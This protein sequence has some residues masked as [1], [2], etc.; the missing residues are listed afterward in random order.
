MSFAR[1]SQVVSLANPVLK[2]EFNH[3]R[4]VIQQSRSGWF[5]IL[6]AVLMIVP[7]LISSVIYFGLAALDILPII[8]FYSFLNTPHAL[9]GLLLVLV[10][11]SLYPVVSLITMGLAANSIRREKVN[12]TWGILILTEVRPA[13]VVF[14]K[15]WASLRA[16]NGDQIMVV[17][18]RIGLIGLYTSVIL[19]AYLALD[20]IFIPQRFYFLLLVPIVVIHA[21]LD[22][23]LTSA[24]GVLA[25]IPE[26]N[27]GAVVASSVIITRILLAVLTVLW[28]GYVLWLLQSDPVSA[29]TWAIYGLLGTALLCVLTLALAYYFFHQS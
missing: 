29:F 17:V 7:A 16:L 11:F 1:L 18:V 23:A 28:L 13:Q 24:L 27:I 26:E 8:D 15:W 21:L 22:S 9:A 20:G 3:Q 14:G 12:H 10:N 4:F 2:A 25:A 6:L 19:P 5:W